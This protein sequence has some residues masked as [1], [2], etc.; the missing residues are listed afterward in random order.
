[1][2]CAERDARGLMAPGST[3][4][5]K[6]RPWTPGAEEG[7]GF[8]K[9]GSDY[10]GK[11]KK[12]AVAGGPRDG[13]WLWGQLQAPT[14]FSWRVV[15]LTPTVWPAPSPAAGSAGPAPLPAAVCSLRDK[16]G[17]LPG[18]TQVTVVP[19]PQTGPLHGPCLIKLPNSTCDR[20]LEEGRVERMAD[21]NDC[22][23]SPKLT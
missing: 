9:A 17:P 10:M 8:E 14:S 22:L 12:P 11:E 2:S 4:E 5:R 13:S 19:W 21:P 1:M 7:A 18:N 6:G 23:L 20:F 3:R 15:A 16:P